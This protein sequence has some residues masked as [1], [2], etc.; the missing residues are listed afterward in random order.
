MTSAIS[1]RPKPKP[2]ALASRG[3]S[4]VAA[5]Q[6]HEQALFEETMVLMPSPRKFLSNNSLPATMIQALKA[7]RRRE[8]AA[9]SRD[10]LADL[11][12]LVKLARARDYLICDAMEPVAPLPNNAPNLAHIAPPLCLGVFKQSKIDAFLAVLDDPKSGRLDVEAREDM[13][14][15]LYRHKAHQE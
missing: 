6:K 4:T 10:T 7:A 2:T 12:W 3:L 5:A 11:D 13:E 8:F 14:A 9:R 1:A 15:Y